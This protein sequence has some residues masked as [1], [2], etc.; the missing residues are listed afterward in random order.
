MRRLQFYL[1]T[2]FAAL[3]MINLF[4]QQDWLTDIQGVIGI[5]AFL[6]SIVGSNR[7]YQTIGIIFF[8]ISSVLF[9]IY[10]LPYSSITTYFTSMGLLLTLLYIIPFINHYMIV[11][12]YDQSL[13]EIL[14][15]NTPN[16]GKF[17]VK[18]Y[19]TSYVLTIFIFLS[20]IPLVFSLIKE[21]TAG[22]KENLTQQFAT[23]AVLRPLAAANTW[24]PIE[25]YIALVVAYTGSSY[26]VLLPVLLGF[27]LTMLL[28][29]TSL[30]YFKYRKIK[31]QSNDH[32][33]SKANY[34][35]LAS[36]VLFLILFITIAALTHTLTGLVFFD[37]IILV[38]IPYTM[39]WAL[40]TKRFQTFVRYNQQVWGE[41]IWTMQNFMMLLLPVGVFNEV[42][43]AT[44][45]FDQVMASFAWLENTP[46][47]LFVFIQL[48]SMILAFFGFHPLVTLSL[49]GLFVT[50]FLDTINPLSISIV[51]IIS[52]ISNDMTGTFNIPITMLNQYFKRNPY[53]LT[54]WNIGYALIF[55]GTGVLI[56]YLL[57]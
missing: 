26:L 14:Q 35:K 25:V 47:L 36:L 21:K 6:V 53:Q 39:L 29:D 2:S 22:F 32:T 19:L 46:L 30:G 23:R 34:R 3:Y 56:A 49:Q 4:S 51:M 44:P 38:I 15:K 12:E 17:Y 54:L 9:F 40:I 10:D 11:G 43:G 45:I 5:G 50:P 42:V 20:M 48:S 13:F 37:A 55:G 18:S 28:L 16:L 7:T 24:S 57:L 52:V 31:L 41:Q 27:S 33:H 1:Y 8:L